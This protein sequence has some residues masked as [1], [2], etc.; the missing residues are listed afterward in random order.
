MKYFHTIAA[1]FI[2]IHLNAQ[3]KETIE[4]YCAMKTYWGGFL[5]E[6]TIEI[7]Y[8]QEGFTGFRNRLKDTITGKII[9]FKSPVEALNYMGKQGWKLVNTVSNSTDN[10]SYIYIFKK[11]MLIL[12]TKE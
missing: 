10:S 7:D 3:Q 1:L 2:V 4:Q 8:G 9:K 12:A 11:E 5:T 6:A